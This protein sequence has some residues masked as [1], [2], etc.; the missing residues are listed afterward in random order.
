MVSTGKASFMRFVHAA[1]LHIDSPLQGLS[2]YEGAPV[3]RIRG[4]TRR[5]LE[6]L[7][8][9]CLEQH[10]DFLLLAGDIYD[11]EWRDYSTGLFFSAQMSRLREAQI[12][13]VL[14]RGNHD[15]K[16]RVARHL[17]LPENTHELSTRRAESYVL[18][19]LD[20]A[21]HGRGFGSKTTTEDLAATFPLAETGL[22]NIGL[23][24][25]SL[26][27]REGH[28][29][30]A[31]TTVDELLS[32][33]YDY[34]ALGHV[35][36]REIV[37]SDPWIVF[38]GNLQGRHARETGPKGAMVVTVQEGAVTDVR[39]AELDVVRWEQIE[40]EA[41]EES[42]ADAV[43]DLIRSRLEDAAE[44]AED[45]L[46]AARITV[47]GHSSAHDELFN[48]RDRWE[49]EIR[50]NATD[51]GDVWVEKINFQTNPRID[52]EALANHDDALGQLVRRLK[53]LQADESA[54]KA[55]G[56]DLSDLAIKLPRD[57][58]DGADGIRPEDPAFVKDALLDVERLL[59]PRLLGSDE[60]T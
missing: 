56:E 48:D 27:G 34:W 16:S 41:P 54:L 58:R 45:R 28:A 39:H 22:F 60:P 44:E 5:A 32:K 18:E 13:V 49:N 40:V 53:E 31:P 42:S 52:I 15:A 47:S 1:D 36:R 11:G 29:S 3:D 19:E 37:R 51:L 4:A 14:V 10:I 50:S 12:P 43:V 17:K 20:V 7:V 55:L 9:L 46:L 23:L 35:H 2:N 21:I 25:T 8:D 33:D 26:D 24:H 59:L 30:Y 6:K 57:A 38:P